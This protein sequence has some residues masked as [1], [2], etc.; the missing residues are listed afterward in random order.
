MNYSDFLIK[1]QDVSIQKT[2]LKDYKT[3]DFRISKVNLEFDL[4]PKKTTV[5]SEIAIER[6]NK[7]SN[8]LFLNG[9]D[10]KLKTIHLNGQE[11]DPKNYEV[12]EKGITLKFSPNSKLSNESPEQFTLKTVCI[13]SPEDN[14]SLEGLYLS[15]SIL[16]TQN[17][18]EGFRK[19]TYFLDRPDNMSI[20]TVK[21]TA[22]KK[23]Y[24]YLLA[25]GNC[26]EKGDLESGQH[27]AKWHDPFPKPSYLFALV[28]GDLGL[29]EDQFTTK[30]GKDVQLQIYCD[31]GQEERCQFAMLSL[32]NAM[33]W[34]EDRFDL[35]YDL[36]QYMI[37][38]V[39]SF[40]AGAMENKG[41]N[42]FNSALVLAEQKTATDG[43]YL[44]IE[45][46]IAHEYFH[47]WTGNRVTCRDWFQLTL[48]EG[49]TV[50][51]DQEFSADMNSK[52]VQ[53]IQE[54]RRL[55]EAQY[56]EDASPMSHPI[57]PD[58]YVQ[59][60]NFYT[61]TVYEKGAEVIRMIHTFVGE[62]G[63]QK[64]MKKYF[65]L[66]D[67]KAVTTEDFLNAMKLANSHFDLEQFKNWY[68]QNGTP[69]VEVTG[70]FN[71]NNQT[72]NLSYHQSNE[73]SA[74]KF[75]LLI[76]LKVG[77]INIQGKEFKPNV[78]SPNQPYWNENVVALT[79][80]K[81]SILFTEVSSNPTLSINRFLSAPVHLK[82][83][84]TLE[85]D[86]HLLKYDSDHFNRYEVGQKVISDWILEST[87]K[88]QDLRLD[89]KI[90]MS[91]AEII[92]DQT[93]D[94]H[95]KALLLSAPTESVIHQKQKP[96]DFINTKKARDS[97]SEQM[98]HAFENQFLKIYESLKDKTKGGFESKKVGARAL[99]NLSLGYL[100]RIGDGYK[101]LVFDHY[102]SSD[103]M[104]DQFTSLHII[105]S[106][107]E[108]DAEF[109][110]QEFYNKWRKDDLVM[111][112]WL[113]TQTLSLSH[114]LFDK[115]YELKKLPEYSQSVPNYVRSL[116]G[117]FSRNHSMFHDE[118]GRGYE[119][120]A[121]EIIEIDN[122][123]RSVAAGLAKAYRIKMSVSEKNKTLINIQL[124]RILDKS[125][126]SSNLSEVV[127]QILNA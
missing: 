34:D 94:M 82:T 72:Y 22:N 57:R 9:E 44:A 68:S 24:P 3:L 53:R 14:S 76:P 8:Q 118:S 23:Q 60:N 48:K 105:N 97:F 80:I 28:A 41:L 26:I 92:N 46:V 18:P 126:I 15:G 70:H 103:N 102:Y 101:K 107:F 123:N 50:F 98:A 111:Q 7:N 1:G 117:S 58:S 104:T 127:D 85:Q 30:S 74:H 27:F 78:S 31:H 4:D 49:L 113:T 116:W 75:P 67:G 6:L 38:S 13:I 11:L 109:V 124:K 40:N 12:S 61:A 77:F 84:S 99:K 93:I 125:N 42:I 25:N 19:I 32:K 112:K 91:F 54:V 35:E 95:M 2:L 55:I 120:I 66:Y 69:T 88:K 47:N 10:I 90:I 71:Q 43:D 29:I 119:I 89:P 64:G 63:F 100:A 20:Y 52:Y 65:E 79:K 59:I 51:R 114:N 83:Q 5:S 81:D 122:I 86:L 17:E 56:P 21:I 106:F 73:N 115:I 108:K 121:N 37:V 45:S 39:G 36:D 62:T 96:I 87:L 33:K 110:N 16:C